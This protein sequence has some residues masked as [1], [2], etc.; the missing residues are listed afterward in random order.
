M[1][2]HYLGISGFLKVNNLANDATKTTKKMYGVNNVND[3]S[4]AF[5]HM[6]LT[7]IL[8]RDISKDFAQICLGKVFRGKA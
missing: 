4:D 1:I 7:S 2:Y 3:D 8:Y 6:Y 5:R